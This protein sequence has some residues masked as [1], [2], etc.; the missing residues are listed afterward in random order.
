VARKKTI[1]KKTA[2]PTLVAPEKVDAPSTEEQKE[3]KAPSSFNPDKDLRFGVLAGLQQSGD[4]LFEMFGT[5]K[6]LTNLM[7]LQK[8]IS[9]R[10]KAEKDR[11]LGTGDALSL[12][13]AQMMTQLSQKMDVVISLLKKPDNELQDS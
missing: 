13:L 12:Q 3:E 4:F 11:N 10:M 6:T 5:E 8:F 1:E 7:G 9:T 2:E